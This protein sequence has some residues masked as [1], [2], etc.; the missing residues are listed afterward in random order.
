MSVVDLMNA[1]ERG[2]GEGVTRTRTSSGN[3]KS[4]FSFYMCNYLRKLFL[5]AG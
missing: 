5:A 4:K 1:R 2:D 3:S